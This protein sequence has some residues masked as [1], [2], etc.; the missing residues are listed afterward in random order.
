MCEAFFHPSLHFSRCR[1]RTQYVLTMASLQKP[2]LWRTSCQTNFLG[3][4]GAA[5]KKIFSN[6]ITKQFCFPIFPGILYTAC[7]ACTN[8][9]IVIWNGKN[10][11]GWKVGKL[12]TMGQNS[13]ITLAGYKNLVTFLFCSVKNICLG[14]Q[15]SIRLQTSFALQIFY[16]HFK[17][18]TKL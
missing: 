14:K 5:C 6:F 18:R 4:M 10:S 2:L 9:D 7:T 12:A 16:T 11:I 3:T 13:M 1:I 15:A 8:P 17:N